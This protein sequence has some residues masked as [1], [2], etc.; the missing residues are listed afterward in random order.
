MRKC[1]LF[2]YVM[3][4]SASLSAEDIDTK[5]PLNEKADTKTYVV[6]ISNENYKNVEHV[7][8][9]IN[10]G[11][12]FALY[13]EK[14]L[15]IPSNHIRIKRDATLSEMNHALQWLENKIKIADKEAKAIVYYSGH[16]MPNDKNKDAILL[17]V[18]GYAG[19]DETGFPLRDFYG[20]LEGM[21]SKQ[22]IV[23]LDACFSGSGRNDK[24]LQ[25]TRGVAIKTNEI[26]V[27]ENLVV[28]S[29]AQ[30][31]ETAFPYKEM[32]HGMFTYFLLKKLGESKGKISLGNLFDYVRDKVIADESEIRGNKL[33]TPS[34]I[35]NGNSWRD[36]MLTE[37]PAS[38]YYYRDTTDFSADSYKS[39][40]KDSNK[41]TKKSVF[42][43]EKVQM[44]SYTIEGNG[45]G[46]QG[47][48]LVQ[49]TVIAKK[50]SEITDEQL[51]RAAIHGVLFKGFYSKAN[52]QSQEPIAGSADME[53]QYSEFYNDFF[54]EDFSA[55]A[56][57][58][59]SSKTIIKVGKQYKVSAIVCV[60]KDLLRNYLE[61]QEVIKK[62]LTF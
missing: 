44:P 28:F 45:T 9:A 15:G 40:K 57:P 41:Y 4:I 34:V 29:A 33:Q 39:E 8:F 2:L 11:N 61:K 27:K 22:I 23:F 55:Y 12:I 6:V 25:E 43:K 31:T 3:L 32:K 51:M 16:G 26:S 30:G 56:K 48:Y 18:D 62:R 59:P 58:E 10:D 60:S 53:R 5:I 1:R 13:C 19:E 17:P 50:A 52:R 24:M 38:K 42:S 20:R 35:A 49:V 14:T 21:E 46:V 7:P 54:I 37:N 47:T 36:I